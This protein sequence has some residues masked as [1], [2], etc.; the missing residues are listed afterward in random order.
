[1]SVGLIEDL[2]SIMR[3]VAEFLSDL[4]RYPDDKF[5]RILRELRRDRRLT[6]ED[7]HR[8]ISEIVKS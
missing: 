5:V 2:V 7:V 3:R 8:V 4:R 1:M 6:P